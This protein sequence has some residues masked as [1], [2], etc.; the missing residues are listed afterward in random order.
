MDL[1]K[2]ILD[3]KA[4]SSAPEFRRQMADLATAIVKEN[5]DKEHPGCVK[6]EYILGV[7]GAKTSDWIRVLH[8]YAGKGF[9]S[10]ALPEIGSEVLVGFIMGD[11]ENAIVLGCLHNSESPL[12][13]KTAN[14]AN[15]IKEIRTKGGYELVLSEEKGKEKLSVKTPGE[16]LLTIDDENQKIEI[17]DKQGK[18][19]IVIDGKANCISVTAEKKLE[20]ASKE[21]KILLDGASG[22]IELSASKLCVNG[23]QTTEIQ[24]QSLKLEGTSVEMKSKGTL[25]VEASGVAQL[26]GAM[27]KIN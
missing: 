2:E 20:L 22:K 27:V 23:K 4:S 8:G 17:S 21:T 1:F 13:E 9:G 24:G 3:T 26:K 11:M 10:Y 18:D 25:K 16:Q 14:E 7:K 5:W 19:T 15:T 6:V 12:P